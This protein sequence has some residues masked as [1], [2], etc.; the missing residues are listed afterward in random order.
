MKSDK[1]IEILRNGI[2]NV[3]DSAQ[4]KAFL[5]MKKQFHSYS[6]RNLMM[7]HAQ[8][9]TATRVAGFKK[10]Q[11]LDRQVQKGEKGIAI[12]APIFKK[13][14][15]SDGTVKDKLATFRIVY[16]FDVAQTKGKPLP[17]PEQYKMLDSD[18]DGGLYERLTAYAETIGAKVSEKM[19]GSEG[20]YGDCNILTGQIRI[21]PSLS[22]YQKAKTLAHEIAHW[23]LH[24]VE[25]GKRS[26][27]GPRA[28]ETEAEAVAFLTL[29]H[30]GLAV[31]AFSFHYIAHWA[32][33]EMELLEKSLNRID[34][35]AK[36][37]VKGVEV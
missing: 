27:L 2:K 13:E 29:Q 14:K 30:F 22:L 8:R 26:G 6:L 31:D 4:F 23:M 9:P 35:A 1:G 37:L 10:W 36:E 18:D 15:Q 12:W 5:A 34:K 3:T 33:G 21:K 17:E 11:K 24:K 32:N 7:V 28:M 16:V 19:P 25:Q 20:A